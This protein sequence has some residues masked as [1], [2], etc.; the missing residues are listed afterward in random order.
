[1]LLE[2]LRYMFRKETLTVGS[3]KKETKNDDNKT[4][5]SVPK[6]TPSRRARGKITSL[7]LRQVQEDNTVRAITLN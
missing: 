3:K 2:V 5:R 6:K 1:M 7:L 4:E